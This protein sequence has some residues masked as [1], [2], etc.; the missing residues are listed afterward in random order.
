MPHGRT[1]SDPVDLPK[2]N[3]AD[4]SERVGQLSPESRVAGTLSIE[5]SIRELFK[6]QLPAGAEKKVQRE[7]ARLLNLAQ[8]V[9]K[10]QQPRLIHSIE[11]ALEALA[12]NPA[13]IKLAK[14]IRKDINERVRGTPVL[15]GLAAVVLAFAIAVPAVIIFV[16]DGPKTIWGFNTPALLLVIVGG[17]L[18]SVISILTRIRDFILVPE[19]STFWTGA[20]RPLIGIGSALFL[21]TVLKAG[22]VPTSVEASKEN[23]FFA[24]MA[25]TAGFS[26]RLARDVVRRTEVRLGRE[27]SKDEKA[28]PG[29]TASSTA[30]PAN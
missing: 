28:S 27:A 4:A 15:R 12:V 11:Y 7:V 22:L 24:A 8:D 14:A 6:R 30:T 1:A 19:R 3:G 17:A 13:N 23:A 2:T 26:E 5:E 29:A 21:Y 25:F 18:G 16:D 9:D 20:F 10:S